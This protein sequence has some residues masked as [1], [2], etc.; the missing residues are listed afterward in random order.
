M[1]AIARPQKCLQMRG[2]ESPRG[3]VGYLLRASQECPL[4]TETRT[5]SHQSRINLQNKF[6]SS[7]SPL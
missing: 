3:F 1:R 5:P 4:I 2:F 7:S 6:L